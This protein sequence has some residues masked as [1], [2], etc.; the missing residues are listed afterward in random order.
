MRFLSAFHFC[1]IDFCCFFLAVKNVDFLDNND[2]DNR[3][4]LKEWKEKQ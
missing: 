3:L 4:F 2:D 1:R